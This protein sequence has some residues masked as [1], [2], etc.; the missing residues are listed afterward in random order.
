MF[1]RYQIVRNAALVLGTGGIIAA[2]AL[3][4]SSPPGP[5]GPVPLPVAPAPLAPTPAPTPTPTPAAD[6]MDSLRLEVARQLMEGQ[7]TSE[8]IKDLN[9]GRGPKVSLYDDDRDGRWDRAK[10][11][12]DRD[13]NWDENWTRKGGTVERKD[14]KSSKVLILDGGA[15]RAK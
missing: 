12:Y 14:L 15:W 4:P 10:V 8:R 3:S 1:I 9:R 5:P 6:P 11:D 7:A 13:E 2:I